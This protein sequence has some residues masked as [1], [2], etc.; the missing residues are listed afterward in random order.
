MLVWCSEVAGQ[1]LLVAGLVLLV[2]GLELLVTGLVLLV[3]TGSLML[4]LAWSTGAQQESPT[5]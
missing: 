5:A 4:L 1:V 2:A 3:A